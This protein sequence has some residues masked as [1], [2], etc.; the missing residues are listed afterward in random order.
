MLNSLF[1]NSQDVSSIS[2]LPIVTNPERP[3]TWR[4]KLGLVVLLCPIL[5]LALAACTTGA[6]LGGNSTGWSPVGAVAIPS[7]SGVKINEGRNVD[8]LDISFTVT[9]VSSFDLGQVIVIDEERLLIT[10]I[11]EQDLVVDRGV[12]DTRPQTHADQSVIYTIG[13]RFVVFVATKQGTM[14]ALVDDG[15]EDPLVHW[16]CKEGEC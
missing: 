15:L 10:S 2:R 8:P 5:V 14:Q 6:G 3:N 13:D 9:D 4:V 1:Q 12:D 16:I 11:R 7:D